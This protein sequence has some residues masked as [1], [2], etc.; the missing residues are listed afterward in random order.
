MCEIEANFEENKAPLV[1]I[2]S[3]CMIRGTIPA[4]RVLSRPLQ[5]QRLMV[6]LSSSTILNERK[7]ETEGLWLKER[8]AQG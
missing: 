3:P 7:R 8:D 1:S 2:Y 6:I 5:F 4:M